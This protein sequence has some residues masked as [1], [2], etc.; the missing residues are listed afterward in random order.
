MLDAEVQAEILERLR[1]LQQ[2]LGL[3][4]LFVTHD[5]AVA[6]GGCPDQPDCS[7]ST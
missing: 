1:D 4:L 2:R 3:G 5:L 7:A 6:S